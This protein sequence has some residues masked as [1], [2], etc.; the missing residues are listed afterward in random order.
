MNECLISHD[1]KLAWDSKSL[2][3]LDVKPSK[4][5]CKINTSL[6]RNDGYL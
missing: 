2:Q 5:D 3:I 6:G 4:L 1:E